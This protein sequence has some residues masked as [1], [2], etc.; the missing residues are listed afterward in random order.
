MSDADQIAALA[1]VL[2]C[3]PLSASALSEAMLAQDYASKDILIHQGDRNALFW[4]ILGGTVQLQ[5]VS[6]DGQ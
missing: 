5:A 2:E 4:L 1:G 6:A 3:S